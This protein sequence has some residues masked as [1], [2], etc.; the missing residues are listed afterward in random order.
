MLE[1]IRTLSIQLAIFVSAGSIRADELSFAVRS[2]M[3][4]GEF[5]PMLI[6]EM[7]GMP[8]EFPRLQ[9]NTSNGYRLTMSRSRI[10]FFLELPLGVDE[11]DINNF[12][13]SCRLLVSILAEKE[14]VLSRVGFVR[15]Y[16]V[17]H[18]KANYL[19][20]SLMSIPSEGIS[21]VSISFTQ[22]ILC[23]NKQSNSVFA[24]S[25]GQNQVGELGIAMNRDVNTD[26]KFHSNFGGGDILDYIVEASALVGIDS[27]NEFIKV[28]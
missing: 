26:P 8:D 4:I 23:A 21:E 15:T 1:G 5:E 3:A 17:S 22:K 6:P 24:F 28:Q 14:F 27:L 20:D 10:D 7:P 2:R 9:I 13:A 25:T 11:G 18:V 12:L 16:F 19:I